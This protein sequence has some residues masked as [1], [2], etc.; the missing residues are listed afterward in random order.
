MSDLRVAIE[1]LLRGDVQTGDDLAL[2]VLLA[3]VL[4]SLAHLLTMIVTRWG[5]RHTATKSFVASLLVHCVCFFSFQVLAPLLSADPGELERPAA[6]PE[7]VIDVLPAETSS[8]SSEATAADS[9]PL[10]DRP[11]QLPP[12]LERMKLPEREREAA[13]MPERE[14]GRQGPLTTAATEISQFEAQAMKSLDAPREAA[15]VAAAPAFTDPATDLQTVFAASVADLSVATSPRIATQPIDAASQSARPEPTGPMEAPELDFRTLPLSPSL[16]VV[17]PPKDEQAMLALP[18]DS[19]TDFSEIRRRTA[20]PALPELSVPGPAANMAGTSAAA[21]ATPRPG[22]RARLPRP[23][24]PA[25][26]RPEVAAPERFRG[27]GEIGLNPGGQRGRVGLPSPRLGASG[28]VSDALASAE[29]SMDSDLNG[30]LRSRQTPPAIYQL[31]GAGKRRAAAREFGGT[32]ESEQAVERSLRWLASV[33]SPDGHWDASDYGSGQVEKDENGA[34]RDFAGREA[35]TGVTG[36]ALLCF[37]GAGYTHEQGPYTAVVARGLDW[38]LQQQATDG[39]LFGRAEPFAQMYCHAIAT[40]ALAEAYA[41]LR[42]APP[43]SLLAAEATTLP[44][45][46]TEERLRRGVTAAVRLIIARQ[47]QSSGGWRYQPGQEGDLSMLGWQLMALKSAEIGGLAMP[48]RVRSG[49][50]A[51]LNRSAQGTAGGLHSYRPPLARGATAPDP[52]TP[53]MTAEALFCRQMLGLS[54]DTPATAEAI[55]YL[56]QQLPAVAQSNFYYWY[57]G[58]LA[59]H[60]HGGPEWQTW[61]ARTREL[62]ISQQL[63]SGPFAGSWDPTDL[64]SRYGGRLYSTTFATLTLEVYYRLLPLQRQQATAPGSRPDTSSSR[65]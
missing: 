58:S 24:R 13:V 3:A 38:L 28:S 55:D 2:L 14:S 32:D 52:V 20:L 25:P 62:L 39:N 59:L 37:L 33:Q 51:F 34:N 48:L 49:V 19:T 63:S 27:E 42:P 7:V 54:Q 36:L 60:Q 40:Y 23:S 18:E 11:N 6:E 21:N 26:E 47:D 65:K 12:E 53:A 61:N 9:V 46:L 35:D 45:Q 10:A 29:A 44:Q 56:S 43:Q 16:A 50:Q 57:Y 5:D 30:Q 15:P 8:S 31:R 4:L 1:R 41:M 22:I 17:P 64:W